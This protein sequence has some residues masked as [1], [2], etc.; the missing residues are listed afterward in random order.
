MA[1]WKYSEGKVM[2]GLRAREES[3]TA[4]R[5]RTRESRGSGARVGIRRVKGRVRSAISH[6]LV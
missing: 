1:H 4:L 5:E 3:K 6:H 2:Q